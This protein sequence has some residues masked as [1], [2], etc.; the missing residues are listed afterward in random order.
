MAVGAR[1]RLRPGERVPLDGEIVAGQGS[2]NQAPITGESLPVA[3]RAG[4]K[5]YAGTLNSQWTPDFKTEFKYAKT[6]YEQLTTNPVVLPE[7][8]IM[9][10]SGV[11]SA[12]ANVTRPSLRT[13]SRVSVALS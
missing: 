7:V 10:V 11:N 13:E 5:V 8:R 4:E 12:G 1:V 6:S 2:L 3:K 9:G